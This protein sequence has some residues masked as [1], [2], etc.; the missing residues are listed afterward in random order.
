MKFLPTFLI[1]LLTLALGAL[2]VVQQVRG[3]LH[4]LFGAPP[5]ETGATVYRFD[6][7]EVGRILIQSDGTQAEVIKTDTAWMLREPWEDYADARTVRSLIDFAARLQIEDVIDRDDVEDPAGYGLEKDRIEVHFFS[8]AGAPLCHFGIGRYTEWRGFDPQLKPKDPTRDPPSFP[9]L[10]I[11]PEE[12]ELD[13]YL[14]VC[15]DFA[16]PALRTVPVRDLFRDQLRLFRDHRLFNNS[17]SVAAEITLKEKNSE[18]SLK[19]D[20]LKKESAWEIERPYE[21]ATSPKAMETLISGLSA[22]QAAAVVDPKALSLPPPLPENIDFSIKIRY[23]KTDGSLSEP[24][25]ALFYPPESDDAQVVPVVIMEDPTKKRPA[26]LLVPRGPN[27][28]LD[29]LPRSVNSLRSRTMTA[30]QVRDINAVTLTDFSGRA[31]E[32]TLESVPHERSSRWF[33]RV[34]REDG[35][36]EI[37]VNYEGPANSK[38]VFDL[39]QSLFKNEVVSFTNDS[40]TSPED[41]GLDRPIKTIIV[42]PREGKAVRFVIGSKMVPKYYARQIPSGRVIEI[43]EEAYEAGLAGEGHG[44]LDLVALPKTIS[45]RPPSGLDLFGLDRP[46]SIEINQTT[47]HLGKT[48][49]RLFFANQLDESGRNTPHVVQ[50]DPKDIGEMPLAAYHWHNERLWNINRFEI[51]GLVIKKRN[52]PA[53]ELA[54]NFYAAKPWSATR[55]AEEVT[56]LL[57]T[58]KAEKLLKKLTEIEVKQ[59]IGPVADN[60]AS[61]LADPSLTI[62]VLVEEMTDEGFSLGKV[63][64]ELKLSEVVAGPANRFYFGKSDAIPSY[65]LI[66][67]ALHERL[68][69]DLLEE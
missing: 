7:A 2:A 23:F 29:G 56:A 26:I 50:I 49:A 20:E 59:W 4:F 32:L 55:G 28:L 63:R 11:Q 52:Q 16:N 45:D 33:A 12:N 25:T 13:G 69:V 27:S 48:Q 1:S 37:T 10:I 21:L 31:V 38:Q 62:S 60:A 30:M 14:Y 9:T 35:P 39:F 36:D 34:L 57:N 66:D 54:Y 24:V 15:S 43:S 8:Q 44:E 5:L 3:N 42:H 18:I 65:F 22:L 61:R 19:R 41:Y 40:T 47:V 6:P 46:E 51:N 58:N 17:P 53:L 67:P 68:A 64:H